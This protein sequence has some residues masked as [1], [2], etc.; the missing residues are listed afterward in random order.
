VTEVMSLLD[1]FAIA[2]RAIDNVALAIALILVTAIF[3]AVGGLMSWKMRV[4]GAMV[5]G[6]M[7]NAVA[8]AEGAGYEA[9]F[10]AMVVTTALGVT[11]GSAGL[12][13]RL[14]RASKLPQV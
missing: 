11:L 3:A 14:M 10:A 6:M 9:A 5:G 12:I 1:A 7:V 4:W 2:W 13:V 8:K